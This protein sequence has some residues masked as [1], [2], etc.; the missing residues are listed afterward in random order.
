VTEAPASAEQ[1]IVALVVWLVPVCEE[2]G[3]HHLLAV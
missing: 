2:D 3:P 1:D